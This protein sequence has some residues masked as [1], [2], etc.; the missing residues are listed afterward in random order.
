MLVE[1]PKP[2]TSPQPCQALGP[3][4]VYRGIGEQCAF[5]YLV[6]VPGW[7]SILSLRRS[8]ILFYITHDQWG[9]CNLEPRLRSPALL[10]IQFSVGAFAI[11][12]HNIDLLVAILSHKLGVASREE[13]YLFVKNLIWPP[14]L[15]WLHS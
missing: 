6:G 3:R 4:L 9:V 10:S 5:Y 7:V 8:S 14:S 11:L 12:S 1:S 2:S 13:I 15:E